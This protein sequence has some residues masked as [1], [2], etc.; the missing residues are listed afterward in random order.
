MCPYL[1]GE[2]DK[3]A[4][5]VAVCKTLVERAEVAKVNEPITYDDVRHCYLADAISF[6][7]AQNVIYFLVEFLVDFQTRTFIVSYLLLKTRDIS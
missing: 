7:I 5:C 4:L 6:F 1:H 3:D 2:D